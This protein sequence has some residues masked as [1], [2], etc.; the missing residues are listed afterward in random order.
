MSASIE[1]QSSRHVDASDHIAQRRQGRREVER[2]RLRRRRVLA[3]SVMAATIAGATVAVVAASGSSGTTA[4][5]MVPQ[6]RSPL[7]PAR[8]GEVRSN[9]T[10]CRSVVH[11][12][13]STSEGLDS[14]TYLPDRSQRIGARYADVGAGRFV[15]EISGARSIVETLPGQTNGYD[16]ARRLVRQGYHGCWVLALGTNEAADVAVGSYV[17]L[18]GRIK[19]MMS[20]IGNQPVM[21]VNAKT[22]LGSGSYAEAHMRQWDRALVRECA[23]YPNMRVYD[24]AAAVRDR[25]FIDDGIHYTSAGYA[26]RARLIADALAQAFPSR[27][28]VWPSG[29]VVR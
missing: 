14:P 2:R 4:F 1:G 3:A 16:V 25:W 10:S 29:C 18:K 13:D 27:R 12:G 23:K 7:L 17:G 26:A 24:W 9:H 28:P 21:W 8:H 6:P 11:I 5:T 15:P 20:A 19:R 22:L